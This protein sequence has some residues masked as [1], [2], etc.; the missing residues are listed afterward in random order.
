MNRASPA[1]NRVHRIWAAVIGASAAAVA[2]HYDAPWER[3][4]AARRAGRVGR[5]VCAA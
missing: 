5:D 4:A 3:S 1:S 2:I